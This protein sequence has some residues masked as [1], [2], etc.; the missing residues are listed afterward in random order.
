MQRG[1][2]CGLLAGAIW[3]FIFLAPR[4][5]PEFSPLLLSAGRYVM[6]GVVSV[7]AAWPAWRSLVERLT[8]ADLVA[9][10][11]L[12]VVG[13]LLYFVLLANAVQMI[14]IAPVS[15]IVGLLPVTVTLA[16]RR[17][18][19]AVDLRRL[20]WPLAMMI[21]GIV[22]INV[23]VFNADVAGGLFRQLA[24]LACA[25]GALASWT[26]YAVVNARYLQTHSH[27]D[28]NEWSVLWG[29]VTG[30]LGALMWVL[31]LVLPAGSVQSSVGPDRWQLFWAV[32]FALALG[33]SWVGNMLWNAAARRLPLTL[34]GQM[35][36]FETLFALLYGF[37][38]D[39]RWPRELEVA[40]IVLLLT[41]VMWSVHQHRLL[42]AEGSG[43]GAA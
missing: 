13:N 33:G 36:A 18:R 24:G 34:S 2:L 43:A 7:I 8:R 31:F 10:L 17:D 19:G 40:A 25:V 15:L 4:L 21:A 26:W 6:Y 35:I 32:S 20:V 38:Y 11:K 3:G 14:G 29:V 22:C 9:L 28:G 5:L 1:V 12:A 39:Q 37:V 27:F 23:D 30:G 42:P 41:G 16:G